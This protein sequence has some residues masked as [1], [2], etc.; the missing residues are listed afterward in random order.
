MSNHTVY[1]LIDPRDH[2]VRYIG[3]TSHPKS[4]LAAHIRDAQKR[5]NTNKKR[6]IF[7]LLQVGMK[8]VMVI[9]AA[10][11]NEPESRIRESVECHKHIATIYNIHDP[12]K[13]G[14]DLK[15]KGKAKAAK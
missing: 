11:D 6:W 15:G 1:H 3:N 9:I 12:S 4:R 5:Q 14:K 2:S 7:E 8:P 13:G 10:Y